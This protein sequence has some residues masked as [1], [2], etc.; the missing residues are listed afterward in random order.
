MDYN[1]TLL[2]LV[3]VGLITYILFTPDNWFTRILDKYCSDSNYEP[4]PDDLPIK[5]MIP[6][7]IITH[8]KP[9]KKRDTKRKKKAEATESTKPKKKRKYTRR[10]KNGVK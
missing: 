8:T 7:E 2:L 1:M 5:V 4:T 6:K 3:L 10:K 9:K